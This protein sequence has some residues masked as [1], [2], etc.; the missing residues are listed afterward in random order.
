MYIPNDFR[1]DRTPE[2]FRWREEEMSAI[3]RIRLPEGSIFEPYLRYFAYGWLNKVFK[4]KSSMEPNS[5]SL[6]EWL[7]HIMNL[8]LDWI[9]AGQDDVIRSFRN[10]FAE[11]VEEG[12]LS[13]AQVELKVHHV[14]CFYETVNRSMPFVGGS[15][16]PNFVGRPSSLAP[17]TTRQVGPI[18]RWSGW[19]NVSRKAPSRPTPSLDAVEKILEHLRAAAMESADGSWKQTL[20]ILAAERNWLVASC[21]ARAGLRRK[22]IAGLSVRKLAEAL[23]ELGIIRMPSGRWRSSVQSNPLNDAVTDGT[24]RVRILAEIDKFRAR[25]YH[26]MNVAVETKGRPERSVMFPLD[27]VVDLLEIGVWKARTLLFSHWEAQGKS[28]LDHDAV[29]ISSTRDGERLKTKSVGDILKDAFS[30][31]DEAGSGHRLRAYFLTEMAW[32]L[33]NQEL[34]ISG[35]KNEVTVE[36]NVLNRLATIAGHKKPSALERHYLDQ[37]T[38]RHKMKSNRPSIDARKDMMNALVSV[39]WRM[40][41]QQCGLLERLILAFD[42][43]SD[44]RFFAVIEAAINKYVHLAERPQPE[45]ASHLRLIEPD[46]P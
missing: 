12:E 30:A 9:S 5:Y 28:K 25:G 34:A 23:G 45:K 42:E 1:M 17:I 15:R 38:L 8:K 2:G 19:N 21:A 7:C 31:T 32:L 6:R 37:A 22:E 4:A 33:W 46:R 29:F 36:N 3:P 43:C 24:L 26:T 41:E 39:S 40:D 35:Y 44:P 16:T 13:S 18:I 10:S 11:N 27:L 20:R 14:F